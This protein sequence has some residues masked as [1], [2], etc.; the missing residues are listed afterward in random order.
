MNVIKPVFIEEV[1]YLAT[2]HKEV[3]FKE[4]VKNGGF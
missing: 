4:K 3:S 1:L 2:F